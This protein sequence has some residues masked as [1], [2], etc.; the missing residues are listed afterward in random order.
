[1]NCKKLKNYSYTIEGLKST[2]VSPS[3]IWKVNYTDSNGNIICKSVIKLWISSNRKNISNYGL[4]YEGKVYQ[5]IKNTI[6]N[7]KSYFVELI[8]FAQNLSYLLRYPYNPRNQYAYK[9]II[10]PVLITSQEAP[11]PKQPY[12]HSL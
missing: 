9:R 11:F 8:D 1:M 12:R 4:T 10:S 6:S 7:Y 5:E 2:G 3:D